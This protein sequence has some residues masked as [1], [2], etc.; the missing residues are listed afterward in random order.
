[1]AHFASLLARPGVVSIRLIINI[2]PASLSN[3]GTPTRSKLWSDWSAIKLIIGA[4]SSY[5][6]VVLI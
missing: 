6:N 5:V 4:L 2:R 1:M 3:I